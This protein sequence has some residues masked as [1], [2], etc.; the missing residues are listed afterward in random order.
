MMPHA[1]IRSCYSWRMLDD[2]TL[3]SEEAQKY[4]RQ[5]AL[6]Y[7]HIG[8]SIPGQV[9]RLDLYR[10]ICYFHSSEYLAGLTDGGDGCPWQGLRDEF[11]DSEIMRILLQTAVAVRFIGNG[12]AD[13]MRAQKDWLED[14]VGKL[15]KRVGEAAYEPL[16]LREA[17]NK[18]I[19]AKNITLDNNGEGNPYRRF[20]KRT[21]F[22]FDDFEKER[23]WKAAIDLLPFVELCDVLA[24]QFA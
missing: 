7:N 6:R 12:H 9:L 23:G 4:Q 5:L 15:Y 11:E 21:I 8:L 16:S 20:I 17:C 3:S 14:E 13:E 24:Q 22:C 19:H 10:L 2:G 1:T 18:I